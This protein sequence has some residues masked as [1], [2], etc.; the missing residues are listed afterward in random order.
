MA[1]FTCLRDFIGVLEHTAGIK[2]CIHDIDGITGRRL[3]NIDAK[4]LMH[5]SSFCDAAKLTPA[6]YERCVSHKNRANIKAIGEKKPFSGLCPYGLFEAVVPVIIGARPVC[7][8][9]AGRI[10]T[11]R[12][13]AKERIENT[14][15]KTG[16]L[17]S[18]MK[19]ELEKIPKDSPEICIKAAEALD[20]FIRLLYEKSDP[21]ENTGLHWVVMRM[22]EYADRNFDKNLSLKQMSM[23]YFMEEKYLGRLF[24]KQMGKSFGEYVNAARMKKAQELLKNTEKKIIDIA[25]SCGFNNVTYF[26][27]VF[28][29][30]YGI[31]PAR[32]RL[33]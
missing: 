14:C 17:Q 11:D 6:G 27:R 26:N 8:I 9:Y 18:I 2:I 20:T 33:E 4:N 23:L 13:R 10:V 1:E 15:E 16:V 7:I 24:K 30:F 21:G 3:L 29:R 32:Y 31:S 28:K 25:H 5:A 22:T 12:D 19:K